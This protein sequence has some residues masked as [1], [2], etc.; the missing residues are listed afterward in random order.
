MKKLERIHQMLGRTGKSRA[1]TYAEIKDGLY[2][3]P[4]NLGA[5]AVAWVSSEVDAYL[6]AVIA[7]CSRDEIRALVSDLV[8]TR[9]KPVIKEVA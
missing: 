3:P 4:I 9:K 5:R 2:P 7:G 6:E 8:A 1:S